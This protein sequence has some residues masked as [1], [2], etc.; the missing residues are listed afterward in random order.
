M[1]NLNSAKARRAAKAPT[2]PARAPAKKT[3]KAAAKGGPKASRA[4]PAPATAKEPSKKDKAIALLTRDK[5]VSGKALAETLGWLPHTTRGF[6]S[7]LGQTM[8]IETE[9][10]ENGVTTYRAARAQ[11]R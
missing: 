11:T 7:R 1:T 6:I 4:R 5:G 10:T 3:A 2:K 9:R 8:T